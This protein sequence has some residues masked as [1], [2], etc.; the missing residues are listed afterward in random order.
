MARKQISKIGKRQPTPRIL[1]TK[2]INTSVLVEDDNG[3]PA[4]RSEIKTFE[5]R[6]HKDRKRLY[7]LNRKQAPVLLKTFKKSKTDSE[8][9]RDIKSERIPIKERYLTSESLKGNTFNVI[10]T[11]KIGRVR[12]K[13]PMGRRGPKAPQLIALVRIFDF[14]KQKSP[15]IVYYLGFSSRSDRSLPNKDMIKDMEDQAINNAIARYLD[16]DG[17]KYEDRLRKDN[18]EEIQSLDIQGEIV[19]TRYQ[20]VYTNEETLL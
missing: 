13:G 9:V 17:Y 3:N 19:T 8:I 10:Q 4:F 5:L 12:V 11:N 2:T 15:K 20:Y 16:R 1:F 18:Y 14:R 6:T 7:E